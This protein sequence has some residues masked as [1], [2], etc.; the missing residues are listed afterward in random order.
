MRA[1]SPT[2]SRGGL[3]YVKHAGKEGGMASWVLLPWVSHLPRAKE[4]LKGSRANAWPG[5]EELEVSFSTYPH[6]P[7]DTRPRALILGK[8]VWQSSQGSRTPHPEISMP[9]RS[10]NLDRTSVCQT[11]NRQ[12]WRSWSRAATP[13]RNG[14]KG[15]DREE[16]RCGSSLILGITASVCALCGTHQAHACSGEALHRPL[17]A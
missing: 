17:W 10:Q 2:S 3:R 16:P 12:A 15:G 6:R 14:L 1:L 8:P 5:L 13:S 11:Q 4:S 9:G 7:G